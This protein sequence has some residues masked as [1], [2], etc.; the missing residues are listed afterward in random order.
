[1]SS[2]TPEQDTAAQPTGTVHRVPLTK[3]S[4]F[5]IIT[6]RR[7]ATYSGTLEQLEGIALGVRTHNLLLGWWGIP[8]GL[9]WTPMALARN[10]KAMRQ[11]RGAATKG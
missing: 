3:V 11:L 7:T 10:A 5:L 8:A 1:M 6:Q 9:I 4:S 2:P